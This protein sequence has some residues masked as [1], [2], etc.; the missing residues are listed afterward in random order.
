MGGRWKYGSLQYT[1]INAERITV[2]K[3]RYMC[4]LLM[5]MFCTT[6]QRFSNKLAFKSYH[7]NKSTVLAVNH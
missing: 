5:D 2:T 1:D 4:V 6:K 3:V 7:K